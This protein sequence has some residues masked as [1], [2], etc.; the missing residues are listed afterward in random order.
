MKIKLLLSTFLISLAIFG[1]KPNIEDKKIDS[2]KLE[3][4]KKA[5]IAA[6]ESYSPYSKYKVG[7]AL[8]SKNKQVFSGT[9]IENASYGLTVCAERS[10]IFS[11]ISQG[12]K[13]FKAIAIVTKDGGSPCACCRQVLN[14]FNPEITVLISDENF[15]KIKEY[16][17]KDLLPDAFGPKNLQ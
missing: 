16:I 1:E 3:L 15:T 12:E 6:K 7:A 4:L 14:E 10:S 11:A 9:N 17:L 2:W 5:K 13:D 8:L